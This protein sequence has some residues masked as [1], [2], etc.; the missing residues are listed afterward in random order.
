MRALREKEDFGQTEFLGKESQ[1]LGNNISA[2]FSLMIG[3][4]LWIPISE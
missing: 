2:A 1:V 4:M 3:V